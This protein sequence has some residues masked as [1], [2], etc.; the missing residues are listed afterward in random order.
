MELITKTEKD[1]IIGLKVNWDE[2]DVEGKDIFDIDIELTNPKSI[3]IPMKNGTD[4]NTGTEIKITNLRQAWSPRNI[5]NLYYELSALTP[6]FS[7][8]KDFDVTL[9]NDISIVYSKKVTSDYNKASEI[10]L[11]AYYDGKGSDII[12]SISD[13]YS[14][15]EVTEFIKWQQLLDRMSKRDN[16]LE[17][18]EDLSLGPITVKLSFFLREAASIAGTDLKLSDLRN[19]LDVNAGVKLYRDNFAVKP[20]GLS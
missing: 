5:E 17:L 15:R 3:K 19:F 7:E 12:Y 13:K 20:Y 14:Q 9:Q 16:A 18:T 1:G 8:V 2:F 11:T 4:S 10:D 6:P